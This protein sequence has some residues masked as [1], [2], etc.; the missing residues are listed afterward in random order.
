MS[1]DNAPAPFPGLVPGESLVLFLREDREVRL[2]TEGLIAVLVV[3]ALGLFQTMTDDEA[4][5]PSSIVGLLIALA[6]GLGTSIFRARALYALTDRRV[7]ADPLGARPASLDLGEIVAVRR[8]M[9]RVTLRG[10]GGTKLHLTN[11]REA[12]AV[13]ALIEHR[14][15]P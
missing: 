15:V 3:L 14:V 9:G 7:I 4:P 13:A 1:G 6:T 12:V 10:R 5:R 11:L 2:L 8:F